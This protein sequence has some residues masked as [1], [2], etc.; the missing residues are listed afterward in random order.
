MVSVVFVGM[1][2]R[3]ELTTRI[4]LRPIGSRARG[5]GER[6]LVGLLGSAARQLF[7]EGGEGGGGRS[8]MYLDFRHRYWG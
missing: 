1:I 7:G 2:L 5:M 3:D 6:S 8:K 4:Q